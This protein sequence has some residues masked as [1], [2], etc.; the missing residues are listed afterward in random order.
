MNNAPK[1]ALFVL[2]TSINGD[3]IALLMA[4]SACMAS[5][6]PA[7]TVVTVMIV[8]IK[9]AS[10]TPW[11]ASDAATIKRTADTTTDVRTVPS[12]APMNTYLGP[13]ALSLGSMIL[14][15]MGLCFLLLFLVVM[16]RENIPSQRSNDGSS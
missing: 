6:T 1:G 14:R 7:V 3:L 8:T 10:V 11:I 5:M 9:T 2:V 4:S 15:F 13:F 12:Y 16:I